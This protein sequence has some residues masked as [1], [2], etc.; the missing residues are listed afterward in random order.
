MLQDS[1]EKRYFTISEVAE[2]LSVAPSLLRFWEGEFPSLRPKKNKKGDRQF[3]QKDI[4]HLRLIYELVKEKGY[5]LQGAKDIIKSRQHV[6][7]EKAELI[8]SLQ[9]IRQF[10]IQLRDSL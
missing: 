4:D 3:T 6:P 9:E 5:T 2:L 7:P 8:A 10:L 1:I